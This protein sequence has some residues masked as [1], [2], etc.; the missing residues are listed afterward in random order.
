[1]PRKV[2]Y[3]VDYDEDYDDYEDY[4]YDSDVQ[5]NFEAPQKKQETRPGLWSCPI[6]TFDNEESMSACDICGVLRNPIVNACSDGN[7]NTG[8][9]NVNKLSSL[10]VTSSVTEKKTTI[11]PSNAKGFYSSS[12]LVSE[13]RHGNVEKDTCCKVSFFFFQA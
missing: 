10:D 8:R 5:E 2:N 7:K 13:N 11:R 1:M 4:N 12:A 9:A 6:C 3:G